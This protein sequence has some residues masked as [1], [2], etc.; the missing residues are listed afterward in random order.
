M[1]LI[2]PAPT[3]A[4]AVTLSSGSIFKFFKWHSVVI[5]S[6]QVSHPVVLIFFYFILHVRCIKIFSDLWVFLRRSLVHPVRVVE[7]SFVLLRVS[8]CFRIR[9]SLP[10]LTAAFDVI[11]SN[12]SWVSVDLF[13]PNSDYSIKFIIIFV[14]WTLH[15]RCKRVFNRYLNSKI[16]GI[17]LLVLSLLFEYYFHKFPFILFLFKIFPFY[18]YT[19]YIKRFA[20]VSSL[21]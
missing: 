2:L 13:S 5:H 16:S 6:L 8:V 4:P 20:R 14:F 12:H 9:F 19:R 10:S 21:C 18:M 17:F 1:K 7:I 3:L 11:C 15:P